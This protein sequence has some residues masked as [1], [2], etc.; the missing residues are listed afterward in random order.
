MSGDD[1]APREASDLDRQINVQRRGAS[2]KPVCT[3]HCMAEES[4]DTVNSVDV[5]ARR[6]DGT[7]STV[8]RVQ[9]RSFTPPMVY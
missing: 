3:V 4:L 2:C 7:W 8:L 5:V 9:S 6:A 1:T